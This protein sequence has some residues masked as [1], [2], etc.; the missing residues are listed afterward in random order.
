MVSREES[1]IRARFVPDSF[2]SL[3]RDRLA[4]HYETQSADLTPR[5]QKGFALREACVIASALRASQ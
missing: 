4:S 3:S 5:Q 1:A 2:Q